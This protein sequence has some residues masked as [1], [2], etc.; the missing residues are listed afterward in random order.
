MVE[1]VSALAGHLGPRRFGM[2]GEAGPG[3]RLSE[4]PIGSL[5]Q[6]SAWPGR[7]AE[8]GRAAAEAAGAAEAPAPGRS[9]EGPR[10]RVV[11]TEA[12]KWWVLSESPIEAPALSPEDGT[13]LDLSHARTRIRVEGPAARDLLAR[14]VAIDLRLRSFGEGA[15]AVTGAHGVGLLLLARAEGIDV[16]VLRSFALAVWEDMA[17]IAAQFGAEIA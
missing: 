2:V 9:A 7:L 13:L 15:V 6:V 12:L 11:R 17:E 4:A 1:R 10:G 8:A 3:V 16:H 5:W 14:M